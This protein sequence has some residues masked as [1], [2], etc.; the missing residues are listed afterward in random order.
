MGCLD[1][2][3]IKS[4]GIV[5]VGVSLSGGRGSLILIHHCVLSW[6]E[7]NTGLFGINRQ[8]S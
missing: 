6:I 2:E 4:L 5:C 8:S 3:Y 1:M 7:L